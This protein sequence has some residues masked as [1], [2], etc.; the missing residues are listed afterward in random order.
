MGD[1]ERIGVDVTVPTLLF[2]RCVN[3]RASP[4]AARPCTPAWDRTFSSECRHCARQLELDSSQANASPAQNAARCRQLE[5]VGAA[6]STMS[7]P[8]TH[9]FCDPRTGK[10]AVHHRHPYL[11]AAICRT[12]TGV[13]TG[14]GRAT[15]TSDAAAVPRVPTS[16]ALL[17]RRRDST[18]GRHS[19]VRSHEMR[20]IVSAE[21]HES[22][23]RAVRHWDTHVRDKGPERWTRDK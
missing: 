6:P 14:Y 2:L 20:A 12:S 18:H 21:S 5:V 3:P 16:S 9:T 1:T 4:K 10:Q 8:A 22:Q 23:V 13:Q 11:K 15:L 17:N 7:R 19:A